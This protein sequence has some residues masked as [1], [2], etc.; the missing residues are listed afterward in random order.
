MSAS[1]PS[2]APKEAPIAEWARL[3]PG[4]APAAHRIRR[5]SAAAI[6]DFDIAAITEVPARRA[7]GE[8]LLC[9]LLP[10]PF[11][12]KNAGKPLRSIATDF[13]LVGLDWLLIGALLVPLRILFPRIWLF[14]YAAGS[15]V[16]LMGIALLHA[17]LITLMAYIERV[18]KADAQLRKQPQALGRSIAWATIVLIVY[19]KLQGAPWMRSLLFVAAGLLHFVALSARRRI[20]ASQK[21]EPQEGSARSRTVLI[22]G[23]GTIGQRLARSLAASSENPRTVCGFLDDRKPL[24]GAV[25]GRVSDL[26][27]LARTL[28]VDEIILAAPRDGALAQE[29]LREARKLHLDVEIIPELFGCK[30]GEDEIEHVGDFPLI[31]LHSEK[32]PLAGLAV[33]RFVDVVGSGIALGLFSP[34]LLLIAAVIKFE[35]PGPI[36]YVAQRAGRKARPFRCYKFRTMVAE[37]DRLKADLRA[38]NQRSG[39]FFKISDDPRVTNFGRFLRRYSLD[40]LPQLWN[41]LKGEMSLVGPRPHPLDDFAEYATEHLGRLDVVPGMTGL[42]Q[43]TARRDP[44]FQKGMQLDRDYIRRWSLRLDFQ[45]LMKTVLAVLRGGGD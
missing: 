40:E 37:A 30:L 36:L 28:F 4:E 1:Y 22:V 33:K 43:V 13:A 17:S 11:Q 27:R 6:N 39:P 32:L 35:S 23:A 21:S 14:A 3:I 16:L 31:P 9:W 10:A 34:V 25:I 45:I 15:P 38:Q 44:S 12:R 24:G 41:V 8:E 2:P 5:K 29:V 18:Y 20:S 26:A 42:W 7:S 19:F